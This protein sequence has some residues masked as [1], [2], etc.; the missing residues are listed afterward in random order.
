[1]A[2]DYNTGFNLTLEFAKMH[3]VMNLI[4]TG[5]EIIVTVGGPTKFKQ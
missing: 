2:V 3:Q 4:N 5:A 1:M